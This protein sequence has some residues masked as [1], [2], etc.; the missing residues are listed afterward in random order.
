MTDKDFIL[1]SNWAAAQLCGKLNPHVV[2]DY[3]EYDV[4]KNS[5]SPTQNNS[6]Y[7]VLGH[8]F[9][10]EMPADLKQTM[11]ELFALDACIYGYGE[12]ES[13]GICVE[14]IV[15]RKTLRVIEKK[16]LIDAVRHAV[17]A[18]KESE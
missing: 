5:D 13:K 6:H 11:E 18:L 4:P 12:G 17:V 8:V 16:D 1:Q 3:I 15:N 14:V 10:L 2:G 9:A 7:H